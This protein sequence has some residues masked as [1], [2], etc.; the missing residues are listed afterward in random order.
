MIVAQVWTGNAYRNFNYLVACP[1][2]G[3]ALEDLGVTD[4][5]PEGPDSL[6]GE[7]RAYLRELYR[8]YRRRT[9]LPR[10]LVTELAGNDPAP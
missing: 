9:K 1:E 6:S 4:Q 10:D 7:E 3:E 2:T 8:R 5:H